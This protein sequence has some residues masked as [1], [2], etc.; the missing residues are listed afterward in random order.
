MNKPLLTTLLYFAVIGIGSIYADDQPSADVGDRIV[1][2]MTNEL[3]MAYGRRIGAIKAG[4][5]T[6]GLEIEATA[7]VA[8]RFSDGRIRIEHTTHVTREDEPSSMVTLTATVK[9][10]D[11]TTVVAP[12]GTLVHASP[13]ARGR[14][15]EPTPS[16]MPTVDRRLTRSSLRGWKLRTWTLA[17]EVGN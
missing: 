14:G 11:L 13:S 9:Q 16:S 7:R 17:E 6:P 12:K 4:I 8:Q 3:A 1:I 15:I 10:T 5:P 2:Q